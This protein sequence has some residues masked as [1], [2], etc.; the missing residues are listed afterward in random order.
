MTVRHGNALRVLVG[1]DNQVTTYRE[2]D[3]RYDVQ[4]RVDKEFRDSPRA[5]E[6]LRPAASRR[7]AATRKAV[8]STT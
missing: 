2:G 3:D 7:A 6:R 1:G 4:L 5:L 8:R